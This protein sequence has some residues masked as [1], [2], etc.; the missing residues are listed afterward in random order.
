MEGEFEKVA[1]GI[2]IGGT[3]IKVGLV[4]GDG[5]ILKQFGLKTTDYPDPKGLVDD[6]SVRLQTLANSYELTGIGIGAPNGNF[7]SGS[8]EYAPNLEWEGIVP[9]A[10]WLS[11]AMRIPC[12]L[13]NDANAAALGEMLFGAA[14]GISNFLFITLGTG[15]GSGIVVDGNL[16]YGHGGAAGEI[17]HVIVEPDG[18]P[19]GCGRRGC[20]EQYASAMGL[21]TTYRELNSDASFDISSRE[22][23]ERAEQGEEAALETFERTARVL[24]L[25]LAN[26]VAYTQP[27]AIFL[28]GGL[29]QSGDLLL[30]PLRRHFEA[31]LLNI[32][33]GKTD[34]R[35]SGLPESD[36]AILGAASLI[37]KNE[38]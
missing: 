23:A 17:G 36:A 29:A 5:A 26:S 1:V 16:V 38:H 30:K 8:I 14:K 4:D 27:E 6:L 7:Y 19:C 21:V 20:L 31:N 2:D 24:G 15:L 11:D 32:Y 18:R 3:N 9:L 22:I 35:I 25:A 28:F 34:I 12:I 37:W 10:E 33:Q 13:T